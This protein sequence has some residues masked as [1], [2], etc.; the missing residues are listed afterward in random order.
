MLL[1]E[2]CQNRPEIRSQV[3]SY[4]IQESNKPF[5]MHSGVYRDLLRPYLISY[6]PGTYGDL[7]HLYPYV[8]NRPVQLW[9]QLPRP[10]QMA[11]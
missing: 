3:T 10:C 7:G 5:P 11:I 9:S 1:Y 4:A 2:T 6:R 8:V